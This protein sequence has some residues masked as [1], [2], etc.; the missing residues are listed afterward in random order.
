MDK[1]ARDEEKGQVHGG[2]NSERG[3]W[4]KMDTTFRSRN[5]TAIGRRRILQDEPDHGL[6]IAGGHRIGK[7]TKRVGE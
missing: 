4:K 3:K 7:K 1:G 2:G 5:S 6:S